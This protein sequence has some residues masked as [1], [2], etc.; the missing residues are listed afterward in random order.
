MIDD[1]VSK[2]RLLVSALVEFVPSFGF[3]FTSNLLR[4]L[5]LFVASATSAASDALRTVRYVRCVACVT[6][7][8]NPALMFIGPLLCSFI[9]GVI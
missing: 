4:Q 1:R 6:L 3:F 9:F 7:S 5:C 2:G 8:E